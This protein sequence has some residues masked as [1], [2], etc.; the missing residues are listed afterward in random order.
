MSLE[1]LTKWMVS[2]MI[3][4]RE[5]LAYSD[6][7]RVFHFRDAWAKGRC[8]LLYNTFFASIANVFVGG[9]FYTGF[10]SVN[11]IDIVRVGIIAFIP[12][13]AWAFSLFSPVILSRFR[14][15]RALLL[16]NHLFYYVCV[17]LAT[18]VMPYLVADY[19]QRT[20]WFAVFLFLGNVSN[21]LLGSGATSWHMKFLPD[22]PDRNIYYSYSNM[23]SS[24]V[25]TA[26]AITSALVADSLA[27]S[28]R[29][30]QIITGLR[31]AAFVMFIINGFMVYAVPQEFPYTGLEKKV[32]ILDILIVPVRSRK[33]LLTALIVMLWNGFAN[34]NANTWNFYVLNTV[35]V[36]YTYMYIGSV[37]SALSGVFLLRYWRQA[38]NR[39]SWFSMLFVVVLVTGLLELP[40]GLATSRTIWIY[41]LVS[42]L[43]GCNAVGTSLVFANLFFV[44][45]PKGNTDL[46][47]TFWNLTANI[48]VLVSTVFGAWFIAWTEPRGP[49]Q[50]FGLPFYGSQFLV[51]IKGLLL[52][53]LCV[54]IKLITP[55]IQPDPEPA[56]GS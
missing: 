51:W 49:W 42:V 10:L 54:Y 35:G 39:F 8:L 50:L 22:G 32:S 11:G 14:R 3:P 36:G 41:V 21:A 17:V 5:Q 48:S 6:F 46:Y 25:G 9:V 55:H 13:I 53:G 30:G 20:F 31:L 43:Q 38:I 16:F 37:I 2:T 7:G 28:P 19:D 52:I 15:R 18:T 26:A 24:F 29:Q 45:L 12:Y 56:A 33:F 40:I 1:N 44:N 23:I 34:I 47:I 4:W 27:G